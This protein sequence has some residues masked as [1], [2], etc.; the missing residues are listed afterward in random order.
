MILP[1]DWKEKIK[2]GNLRNT[3]NENQMVMSIVAV[4]IVVLAIVWCIHVWFPSRGGS[5]PMMGY[6]IDLSNMKVTKKPLGQLAPLTGATGKP[7]VVQV[8]YYSCDGC[9]TKQPLYYE[10][11][12]PQAQAELRQAKKSDKPNLLPM[13]EMQA[14]S[15]ALVSLPTKGAKWYYVSSPEGQRIVTQIH[16]AGKG[17]YSI[18]SPH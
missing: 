6:Y 17:T 5:G 2:P 15:G 11:Y 16:C 18:C 8:I 7:T 10:K 13:A 4:V 14:S 12:T 1:Y 3:I 9:K